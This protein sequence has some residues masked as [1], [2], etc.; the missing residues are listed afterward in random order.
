MDASDKISNL[1]VTI[2]NLQEELNLQRLKTASPATATPVEIQHH[3]E[4]VLL[5]AKQRYLEEL[6][7]ERKQREYVE[8]KLESVKREKNQVFPVTKSVQTTL[9]WVVNLVY[10]T[11]Y[12]I[13]AVWRISQEIHI[14]THCKSKAFSIVSFKFI[15]FGNI[16][17]II[18]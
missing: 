12:L 2:A 11:A 9:Q 16:Q 4:E 3:F 15:C 18:I 8:R 17:T 6:D 10:F 7:D 1:K 13:L 14:L 5:S